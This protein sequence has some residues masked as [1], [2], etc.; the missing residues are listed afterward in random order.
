MLDP[1]RISYLGGMI[2][3][4]WD[5]EHANAVIEDP[6]DDSLIV[7][8]RAQNAVIKFYRAT[9]QLKWI[10]GPHENWG[11]PWQP[12]LLNPVG[13]PFLWQ[14]GQ[15]APVL[16]PQGNLLLFDNGNFRASPFATSVPDTAN[17]SRAVEYQIN[18]DTMEVSQVWD[19]GRTNV[20]Q[21][22]YVDHEGNAEPELQ[23]GNVLI[24]FASVKY[25]NGVAPSSYG[26][27][28]YVVRLTEV[29]HDETPG[30]VFDLELTEFDNPLSPFKGCTAYRVHRIPDLYAHPAV[31]VAD[32][33]V[34]YES[35]APRLEFS[36]DDTRT[37]LIQASTNLVDWLAIGVALED[38]QQ[39][40]DFYFEDEES[41]ELPARYYRI[42]TQ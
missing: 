1:L 8:L 20:A 38:K 19:Y 27:S 21:R 10:L 3:T 31:P 40:G 28:A 12:Y 24:D 14:Y 6:R 18:E 5:S 4:V 2:G 17:Y 16:T 37:Y 13:T 30:I 26:P 7:S 36:A 22:L 23:T 41:S 9:G 39:S 33:S 35:G 15:H 29:T 34:T 42:V 32:L 11:A 25:I